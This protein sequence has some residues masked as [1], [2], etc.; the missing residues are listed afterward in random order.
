ML[1][2]PISCCIVPEPVLSPPMGVIDFA[3]AFWRQHFTGFARQT[4]IPR[5]CPLNSV[6]LFSPPAGRPQPG[7]DPSVAARPIGI[8]TSDPASEPLYSPSPLLLIL[9]TALRPS[10]SSGLS[11]IRL[12]S[13]S[14]RIHIHSAQVG[15]VR[16]DVF[17]S[18]WLDPVAMPR[19]FLLAARPFFARRFRA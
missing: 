6:H 19:S 5:L 4:S 1:I 13:H 7:P 8:Q 3:I 14:L 16:L 9:A 11:P 2:Q 18:I 12:L 15:P 17:A 10:R